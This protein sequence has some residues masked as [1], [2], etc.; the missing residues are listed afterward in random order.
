MDYKKEYHFFLKLLSK[1]NLNVLKVQFPCKNDLS[2]DLN[3]RKTVYANIEYDVYLTNFLQTC[4]PHI[5]YKIF[6]EF[7]SNYIVFQLPDVKNKTYLLIGPF[8]IHPPSNADIFK[9]AEEFQ[10]PQ[11]YFSRFKQYF[12]CLPLIIDTDTLL[13]II[14][15]F[16]EII[17]QTPN[18]FHIEELHSFHS[19]NSMPYFSYTPESDENLSE[20][21]QMENRYATEDSVMQIVANGR[22]HEAENFIPQ[23]TVQTFEQRLADPVRNAKNY[24]IIMNTILRK[25]AQHGSVHPYYIHKI[26]SHYARKN[27]LLTSEK[28]A[29]VLL[30]EMMRKYTML[31][32]NYSLNGYSPLIRNVLV[33]IDSNLA[34]EQKLSIH[35]K[36]L[37][38]NPS[39]LSALFKKEVGTTL[40]SYVTKKRIEQAIFL[41]N[42]TKLE[43]QTIAEYCGFTDLCYFSKMFKKIIGK[44]PSAYRDSILH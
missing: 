14:N 8:V 12:E 13:T 1:M 43:I 30:K 34:G 15:T 9:K 32:Q 41:L 37:N 18:D 10:I 35:A 44:S 28:A 36:R 22:I 40:T 33:A 5:I 19:E 24:A 21:K 26:S 31:V 38:T 6:D 39:Y 2:F 11:E 7:L 20:I 25:A 3:I 27:E 29:L 16:F 17:W 42:S 4:K 23:F